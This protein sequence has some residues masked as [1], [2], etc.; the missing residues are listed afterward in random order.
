MRTSRA[1]ISSNRGFTLVE[2][3]IILLIIGLF[4]ALTLP[5]MMGSGESDLKKGA[6]R[7]QGLVKYL[8]NEA[9]LTGQEHRLIFDLDK[10]SYHVAF[11]DEGRKLRRKTAGLGKP[12]QLPG[13][14]I[15]S[16][17]EVSGRGSFSSGEVSTYF[18]PVGWLDETI[19]H[20]KSPKGAELT[21][22]FSPLTGAMEI[23]EGDHSFN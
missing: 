4:S 10:R 3:A 15:F 14:I 21:L 11:V 23:H 13:D 22:R 2:L 20:L 1:G 8:Y 19:V 6:A 17:I 9:A 7:L 18:Y 12:E 5:N 16:N